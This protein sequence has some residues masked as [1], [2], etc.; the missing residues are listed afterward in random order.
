[1]METVSRTLSHS[2]TLWPAHHMLPRKATG[3]SADPCPCRP[4]RG[5][6]GA[7]GAGSVLQPRPPLKR[8]VL[9]V[10]RCLCS[11]SRRRPPS[12]CW[13]V[14]WSAIQ[15][16]LGHQGL[17]VSGISRGGGSTP[18]AGD[19]LERLQARVS[20]RAGQKGTQVPTQGTLGGRG[21]CAGVLPGGN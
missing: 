10:S 18:E 5:P 6:Q 21:Q 4:N 14:P 8:P 2:R 13:A 17:V 1:M 20:C 16:R 12:I 11:V 3:P 19:A 15:D 7:L 9:R